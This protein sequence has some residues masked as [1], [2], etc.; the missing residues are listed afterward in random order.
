M[1]REE[2]ISDPAYWTSEI[3]LQLFR[4]IENFMKEKDI[5]KSQL[6]DLLNCSKGYVT[7]ILNGDYNHRL[8]KFVELSMA[9]G[10]IPIVNFEDINI[11]RLKETLS[12]YCENNNLEFFEKPNSGNISIEAA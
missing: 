10:K 6:A 12:F 3:Q 4:E 7:Q 2:V 1:T 9:I 11:Y 8:N 5:N